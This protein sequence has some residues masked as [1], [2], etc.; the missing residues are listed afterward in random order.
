VRAQTKK[1]TGNRPRGSTYGCQ[2]VFWFV[3]VASK[4]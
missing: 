4:T 2:H 3:F 1:V